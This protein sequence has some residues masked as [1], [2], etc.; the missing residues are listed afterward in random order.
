[1][2][3][4]DLESFAARHA[5][6]AVVIDVREAWEYTDGHVPGARLIPLA[7]LPSALPGLPRTEPVYVIC[8]TGNRSKAAAGLL[9]ATGIQAYSVA[10]GTSGWAR[11]GRPI[12]VGINE[13]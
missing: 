3:E 1:M 7:Q 2:L 11:A 12:V 13:H 4:I 6:G 10:E 9:N 8:A 5:A